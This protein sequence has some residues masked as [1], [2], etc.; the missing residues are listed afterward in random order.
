M[1]FMRKFLEIGLFWKI[2]KNTSQF[3]K[4]K[5]AKPV[6]YVILYRKDQDFFSRTKKYIIQ[7]ICITVTAKEGM[8]TMCETIRVEENRLIELCVDSYD[9]SVPVGRFYNPNC[10]GERFYSL[11]QLILK[12][13]MLFD[14]TEF[15]QSFTNKRGF[16]VSHQESSIGLPDTRPKVGQLATFSIRVLFRQNASWQGSVTWLEKKSEVAFRSVLELIIALDGALKQ[17]EAEHFSL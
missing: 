11:S 6:F 17:A 14:K 7:L 9:D 10:A 5:Y 13:E 12:L 15:P 4:E 3:L 1:G 8:I 2:K 16:G